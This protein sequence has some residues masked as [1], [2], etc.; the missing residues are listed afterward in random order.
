MPVTFAE[1]GAKEEDIPRLVDMLEPE[2]R[3]I[4]NFG[5]I[6][7]AAAAAIYKLACRG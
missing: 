2:K 3:H 6:D 5:I 1:L 7:R 4:S